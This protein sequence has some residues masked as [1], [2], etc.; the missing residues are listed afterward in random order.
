[1]LCLLILYF[2]YLVIGRWDFFFFHACFASFHPHVSLLTFFCFFIL[3]YSCCSHV[4]VFGKTLVH[5]LLIS[6]SHTE[7]CN[8]KRTSATTGKPLLTGFLLTQ[9]RF[10][11]NYS[12]QPCPPI[13]RLNFYLTQF[14]K[15]KCGQKYD[16]HPS[17][18]CH[19]V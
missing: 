12:L 13:A 17:N 9:I 6:Y 10:N 8:Y 1:M 14:F 7:W 2:D 15:I 11:M 18:M 16:L 19:T 5:E 3:F 4:H